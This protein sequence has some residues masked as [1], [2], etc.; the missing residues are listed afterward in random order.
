MSKPVEYWS[1]LLGVVAGVLGLLAGAFWLECLYLALRS[2]L[3]DDP[4]SDPHGYALIFSTMLS[5]P[6]AVTTGFCI[7]FAVPPRIRGRAIA[8]AATVLSVGTG[9]LFVSLFS[10]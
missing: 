9:L 8:V 6:S 2:R 5:V 10:S 1:P 4:A 3:S 7:A